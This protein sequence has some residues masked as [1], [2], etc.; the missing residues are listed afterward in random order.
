MY[1]RREEKRRE[2][3]RGKSELDSLY[4]GSR[5]YLN[6]YRGELFIFILYAFYLFD[7]FLY[8]SS[9]PG[10]GEFPISHRTT[11]SGPFIFEIYVVP[12][13]RRYVESIRY[14]EHSEISLA[15]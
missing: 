1:S 13:M 4:A 15:L 7:S 8:G 2:E 10:F 6:I 14:A 5:K 3:R 9:F 12:R 11:S